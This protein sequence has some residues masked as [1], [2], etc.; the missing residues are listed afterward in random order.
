MQLAFND[1][2]KREYIVVVVGIKMYKTRNEQMHKVV[3]IGDSG[4]VCLLWIFSFWK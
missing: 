3:L 1:N 4:V 2:S